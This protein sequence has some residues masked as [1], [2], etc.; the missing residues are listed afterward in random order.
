MFY[1]Y[2]RSSDSRIIPYLI[3]SHKIAPTVVKWSRKYLQ[4]TSIVGIVIIFRDPNMDGSPFTAP[5]LERYG[6]SPY[7]LFSL[8]KN[9]KGTGPK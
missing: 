1:R 8:D 4:D 9:I 5:A 6:F 2:G 3:P 7:S